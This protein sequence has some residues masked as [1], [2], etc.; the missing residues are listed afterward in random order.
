MTVTDDLADLNE[1]LDWMLVKDLI[2]TCRGRD[3][4]GIRL[5]I[6]RHD[7]LRNASVA[8]VEVSG[9]GIVEEPLQ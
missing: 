6:A 8:E 1:L 2:R 5:A 4:A 9:G 3:E 7:A